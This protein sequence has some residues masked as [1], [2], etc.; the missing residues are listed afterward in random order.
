VVVRMPTQLAPPAGQFTLLR[1][2]DGNG[3]A[4]LGNGSN[5]PSS[6]TLDVL[7][8]FRSGGK[9]SV[10]GDPF[11]GFL[12]DTTPPEVVGTQPIQVTAVH[13][14]QSTGLDGALVDVQFAASSCAVQP[15]VH[16]VIELP[17]HLLVVIRDGG[18]P[19]TGAVQ[20]VRV[21]VLLGNLATLAPIGGRYH[22]VWDP[23]SGAAP[24]CF[25]AFSPLPS[26]PPNV[27]VSVGA[28]VVVAPGRP[29]RLTGRLEAWA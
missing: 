1:N 11:N 3:L 8:A 22:T 18:A 27:G 23:G 7:R 24:E 26:S 19:S 21:R 25:V 28:D 16:D 15:R 9:S 12:S 17:A 4:F 5:D 2:L 10:T 20:N 14:R 13:Q 29:I 6:P